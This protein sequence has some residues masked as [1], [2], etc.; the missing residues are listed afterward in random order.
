MHARRPRGVASEAELR[1]LPRT[2]CGR[3][4]VAPVGV[5]IEEADAPLPCRFA[6]DVKVFVSLV[7]DLSG[8]QLADVQSDETGVPSPEVQTQ[9][10]ESDAA[11]DTDFT[12]VNAKGEFPEPDELKTRL[13]AL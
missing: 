10:L 13:A 3:G 2:P 1:K 4:E 6:A 9:A 7:G 12:V 5:G 11:R 8:V